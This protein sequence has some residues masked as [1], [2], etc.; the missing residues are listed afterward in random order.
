MRVF[1]AVFALC[2]L[3]IQPAQATESRIMVHE[4]HSYIAQANSAF[5]N[6]NIAV[7]RDFL[8]RNVAEGALFETNVKMFQSSHPS[9]HDIW[10]NQTYGPYHYRYPY[11]HYP[12]HTTS[13]Y[14][15]MGK[16]D[17]ISNFENK[18]R[19]IVGYRPEY[20]ITGIKMRPNASQAVIDIDLKE[21]S[22]RYAPY[23]SYMTANVL[24]ANSKCK[25]YLA[26]HN[27][28]VIMTRMDCN[29]HTNMPF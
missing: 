14:Q 5:N 4:I 8:T 15:E 11:A 25:A 6:P 28:R 7:G 23:S 16:W 13:S 2:L 12:Y 18:K 27:G 17:M 29:T 10:W 22:T 24:H 26:K 1:F 21:Y 20:V 3:M 19:L 9:V